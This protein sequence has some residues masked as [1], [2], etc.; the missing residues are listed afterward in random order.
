MNGDHPV[1]VFQRAN[2]PVIKRMKKKRGRE[3]D[4]RMPSPQANSAK[5]TL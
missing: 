5:R 3:R 1:P 4:A 2:N